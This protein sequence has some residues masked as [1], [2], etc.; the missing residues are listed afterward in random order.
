[1]ILIT[2]QS[3]Q[4]K[5][6]ALLF[7]VVVFISIKQASKQALRLGGMVSFSSSFFFFFFFNFLVR[8][9]K[10]LQAIFYFIFDIFFL[11]G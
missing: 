9:T 5:A 8:G 11:I 3:E 10:L 2:A 1:M 4:R 7:F 6:F